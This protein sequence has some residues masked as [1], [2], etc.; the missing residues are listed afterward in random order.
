ML[1][2]E[3]V[4]LLARKQLGG[5]LSPEERR[6]LTEWLNQE[7]EAEVSWASGDAD[8]ATLKAR[9][10]ARIRSDA[11]LVSSG[12]VRPMVRKWVVAAAVV[13]A[14]VAGGYWIV[15]Y[16]RPAGSPVPVVAAVRDVRAPVVNRA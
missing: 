12:R 10:Y 2:R 16:Q 3:Q 13:V 14:L 9:L 5:T 6:L 7:Q 4:V 15:R 8:E 11:G 1:S